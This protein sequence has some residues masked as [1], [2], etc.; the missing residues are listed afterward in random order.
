MRELAGRWQ[1]DTATQPR[2]PVMVGTLRCGVRGK[3]IEVSQT[4][5]CGCGVKYAD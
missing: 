3:P 2:Q 5:P 4:K 1:T